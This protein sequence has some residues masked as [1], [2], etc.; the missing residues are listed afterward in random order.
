[1]ASLMPSLSLSVKGIIKN[2]HRPVYAKIVLH[3]I[4]NPLRART[5]N[6]FP[7]VAVEFAV[8]AYAV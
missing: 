1:M 7:R 5:L 4:A 2:P 3:S 8:Q 6:Y